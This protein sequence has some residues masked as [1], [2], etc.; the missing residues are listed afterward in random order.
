[1][2]RVIDEPSLATALGEKAWMRA[3]EVFPEERML[4]EHLTVYRRLLTR[5]GGEAIR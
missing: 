3:Q 1:M 2:K 4:A 5:S